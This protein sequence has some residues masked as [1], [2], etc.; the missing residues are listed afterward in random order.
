MAQTKARRAC[1]KAARACDAAWR[2]LS[3]L[4][5]YLPADEKSVGMI[6]LREMREYA[7]YLDACTWPDKAQSGG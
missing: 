3:D 5:D 4:M 1:N 6:R 7:D 2:A